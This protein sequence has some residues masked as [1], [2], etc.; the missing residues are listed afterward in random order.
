MLDLVWTVQIYLTNGNTGQCECCYPDW[1]N[2]TPNATFLIP[3]L[4]ATAMPDRWSNNV[5]PSLHYFVL[6]EFSKLFGRCCA[7]LCRNAP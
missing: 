6:A 4:N 1:A 2:T 5:R 7:E 3:Y